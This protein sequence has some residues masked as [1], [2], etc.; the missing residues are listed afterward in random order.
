MPHPR[1]M[2]RGAEQHRLEDRVR[3]R[4]RTV[5]VPDVPRLREEQKFVQSREGG[6]EG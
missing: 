2:G 3:V 5:R 1:G 6:E 4:L